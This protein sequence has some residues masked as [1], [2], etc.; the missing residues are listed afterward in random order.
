MRANGALRR[1]LVQQV[2]RVYAHGLRRG[3]LRRTEIVAE[4]F[5]GQ[6]GRLGHAHDVPCPRHRAAEGMHAT[7][8]VNRQLAGV[9]ENHAAGADG[10]EGAS[11]LDHACADRRRRIVTR[12]ADDQRRLGQPRQGCGFL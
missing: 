10:G 11:V 3:F 6:S 7:L 2:I 4:P 8:G 1:L 9:G 5:Q 12:T